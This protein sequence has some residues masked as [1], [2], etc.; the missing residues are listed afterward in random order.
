MYLALLPNEVLS[1]VHSEARFRDLTYSQ[2]L[3]EF[4]DVSLKDDGRMTKKANVAGQNVT[5]LSI[6]WELWRPAESPPASDGLPLT[7][8]D[9]NEHDTFYDT[10]GDPESVQF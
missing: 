3:L 6:P 2:L 5:T 7:D 4:K 8:R 1:I 10:I 9:E